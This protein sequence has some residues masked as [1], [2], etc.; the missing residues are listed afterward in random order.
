M[1]QPAPQISARIDVARLRTLYE[2]GA[3]WR[4]IGRAFGYES[5]AYVHTVAK[6]LGI[7]AAHDV[8]RR[9]PWDF[10]ADARIDPAAGPHEDPAVTEA[11]RFMRS[12]DVVV[13]R[14]PGGKFRLNG[15]ETVDAAE[16][17]ARANRRREYLGM[18]LIEKAA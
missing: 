4:E 18:P 14:Q 1:A 9:R 16:I 12:R 7:V 8:G 2:S 3:S 17:V 6:R 13:L 10:R 5:G 15:R 11:V